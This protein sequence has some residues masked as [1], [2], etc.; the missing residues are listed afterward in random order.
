MPPQC[1]AYVIKRPILVMRL[2]VALLRPQTQSCNLVFGAF[3]GPVILLRCR[4]RQNIG[5]LC[6]LLSLRQ[7]RSMNFLVGMLETRI[8]CSGRDFERC[9]HVRGVL[10]AG[11]QAGRSRIRVGGLR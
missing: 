7:C 8:L 3:L 6:A 10:G 4:F 5:G 2:E 9:F 11:R 1:S